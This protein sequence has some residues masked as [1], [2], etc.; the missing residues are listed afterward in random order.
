MA[1]EIQDQLFVGEVAL[2]AII[3]HDGKILLTRDIGQTNWDSPGGRLHFNEEPTESLRREIQEE[4]GVD[5]EIGE[6]F[7]ADVF[8]PINNN[9]SFRPRFLLMYRATLIDPN[10]PFVL[11][12]DEIEEARWFTREEIDSIPLWDEYRRT[13]QAYFAAK[14]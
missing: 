10:R 5:A 8:N 7:Y 11:A 9:K 14:N 4:I 1:Q 3:E 12:P 2:K 6:P 13:L